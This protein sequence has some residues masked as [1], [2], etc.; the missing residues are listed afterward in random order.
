MRLFFPVLFV[1]E[2]TEEKKITRQSNLACRPSELFIELFK[3][4]S[5]ARNNLLSE[6]NNIRNSRVWSRSKMLFRHKRH[7]SYIRYFMQ[8][9][10]DSYIYY[11]TRRNED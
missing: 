1:S 4:N 5:M 6:I 3:K 10:L 7:H 2:S 11:G 9:F 8:H